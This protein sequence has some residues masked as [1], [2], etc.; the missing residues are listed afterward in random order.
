MGYKADEYVVQ[1]R[2]AQIGNHLGG[3]PDSGSKSDK[4]KASLLEKHGDDVSLEGGEVSLCTG[5]STIYSRCSILYTFYSLHSL[6][7]AELSNNTRSSLPALFAQPSQRVARAA[8]KTLR[9]PTSS[10]ALSRP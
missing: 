7:Y 10:T 8:S 1:E 2:L 4:G 5:Q 9:A 6:S 3:S